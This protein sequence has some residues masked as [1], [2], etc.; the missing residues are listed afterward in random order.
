[1]ALLLPRVV[2]AFNWVPTELE[3][4]TL[5]DYCKA[6]M[7]SLLRGNPR[8]H[9]YSRMLM[10][11]TQIERWQKRVGSD[12]KHLHHY[13]RGVALLSLAEDPV[14]RERVRMGR[15][16][17]KPSREHLYKEAVSEIAYTR[18][19]SGPSRPLWKPMSLDYGRALAGARQSNQA[20]KVFEQVIER[21]PRSA[22]AWVAHAR[23]VKRRGDVNGSIS[24]LEEA[25]NNVGD[26]GRGSVLF[27]LANY[28]LDLG[29]INRARETTGRAEAAGMEVDRLWRK[30]GGRPEAA[31]E[32]GSAGR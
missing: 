22:D 30:L 20:N 14:R 29:D 23:A 25:L 1:M 26:D 24:I 9:T 32:S 3:F 19:Q 10:S 4:Y 27:W 6:K 28:Q 21:F 7:S 12:F 31:I 8:A 15:N 17:V 13:C 18:N 2:S 16:R 5:P 11:K